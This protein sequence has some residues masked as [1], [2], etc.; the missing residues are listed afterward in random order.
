MCCT[1]LYLHKKVS[2]GQV[3]VGQKHSR[4]WILTIMDDVRDGAT[5][6]GLRRSAV[7]YLNPS[8]L[9]P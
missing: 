1:A 6:R 5:S 4:T 3:A 8:A 2:L 7:K 9:R